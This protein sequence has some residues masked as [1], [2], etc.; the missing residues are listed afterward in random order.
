MKKQDF[1]KIVFLLI[2]ITSYE[3]R[4]T[5][6][7]SFAQDTS[8]LT[9]L[10][11]QIIEAED[12]TEA[13]RAL[14]ELADLYFSRPKIK[15]EGGIP[16]SPQEPLAGKE[17]KYNEFVE[18]LR[19]LAKQKKTAE[20]AANYYIALA[21]YYQLK[22]LEDTQNWDEYFSNGD[23]YRKELEESAQKAIDTAGLKEPVNLYSRLLLWRFHKDE[24]DSL[25][26]AASLDLMNSVLEY[27]KEAAD[28]APIKD[29]ADQF[30]SS[31]EKT[32]A[33]QLYK[34][35][36]DKMVASEIKDEELN[37]IAMGSYQEG[38]L[39]LAEALFDVYA[40]RIIKSI[41]K[42]KSIPILT[43]LAKTLAYKDG[44]TSDPDYAEKIFLKIEEIGGKNIF[45][46]QLLYLR[47]FN[48][49][50][51][52]EYLRARDIYI[53]LLKRYPEGNYVDEAN[54]KIGIIYTYVARDPK[55]GKTYFE[56]LAQGPLSPESILS[57]Y[58][59]GLLSQWEQDSALAKEYYQKLLEKAAG[60]FTETVAQTRERLKE[61]EEI[62]PIE[63]NLKTFLDVSFKE[64]YA[65][66]GMGKSDL[67]SQP[68]RPKKDEGLQVGTAPSTTESGCMQVELQYLWSGDLGKTKPLGNQTTFN[69]SY[70]DSGTKVIN[71]VVVSP[72]DI[73]DRN[74]DILDVD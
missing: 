63:Y 14:D 44:Q 34:L 69:T 21:R 65:M 6:Y 16:P 72:T 28:I 29:I 13:C 17:N 48:L 52:K 26:E 37:R 8:K 9:A 39:E 38:N 35:Y 67:R 66:L 43:E 2:F 61:I 10:T 53:D 41:P 62:R 7:Q 5:S 33:G 31:G 56:K 3:L 42:E 71:L 30:L 27:A 49:E 15:P 19:S 68:Y 47:A 36:A 22:Y 46:E 57:L 25:A 55:S 59:L 11:K 51:I 54:F 73:V 24:Q 4:V 45:D 74:M 12:N 50:K 64:E 32:K 18:F 60:G 23:K 1:L 20:P 40:A 58:Q 70:S